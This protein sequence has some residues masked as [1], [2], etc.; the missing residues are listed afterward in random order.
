MVFKPILFGKVQIPA[1]L[2]EHEGE[3]DPFSRRG[4]LR[5]RETLTLANSPY[6]DICNHLD[7]TN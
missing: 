5:T 6:W 1:D 7:I 3:L 2:L 4:H